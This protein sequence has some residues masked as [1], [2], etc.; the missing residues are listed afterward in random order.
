M[1]PTRR[2]LS[3]DSQRRRGGFNIGPA[4]TKKRLDTRPGLEP[5]RDGDD[6]NLASESEDFG[7]ANANKG[8]QRSRMSKESTTKTSSGSREGGGQGCILCAIC[9]L[10]ILLML[11]S[12]ATVIVVLHWSGT[13]K[14]IPPLYDLLYE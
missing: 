12:T 8:A 3:K 4:S 9:V 6:V 5:L 10:I 2:D 11:T 7:G 14:W 13:I 1:Q